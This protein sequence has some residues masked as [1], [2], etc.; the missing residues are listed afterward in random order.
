MTHEQ[1]RFFV[2]KSFSYLEEELARC[3]EVIPPIQENMN[4]VS[5]RFVPIIVEA[6]AIWDSIKNEYLSSKSEEINH[7]QGKI[8]I[9]TELE[10]S[11]NVSIFLT[12]PLQLLIPHKDM[13]LRTPEW[14]SAYNKL[15]H[16]RVGNYNVSTLKNAINALAALHQLIARSESFLQTLFVANWIKLSYY[17]SDHDMLGIINGSDVEENSIFV[18]E[19]DLF[20]S[21]TKETFPKIQYYYSDYPQD[22]VNDISQFSLIALQS[23]G[24]SETLAGWSDRARQMIIAHTIMNR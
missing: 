20:L 11:E 21:P 16:D 5:H 22:D 10:L 18:V 14:W 13:H 7:K 8:I 23:F 9:E 2:L 1:D 12:N 3:M 19:S 24:T 15:K 4:V 6:C 17:D